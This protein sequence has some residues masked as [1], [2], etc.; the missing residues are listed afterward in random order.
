MFDYS[1]KSSN[2]QYYQQTGLYKKGAGNQYAQSSVNFTSQ[3]DTFEKSTKSDSKKG[4]SNGTKYVLGGLALAGLSAL[5]YFAT[6]GKVGKG[7]VKAAV[8]HV[9][10]T[11]AKSIDEAKKFAKD[12]LGVN[13]YDID[14][15]D[16]IN[17]LNEWLVGIHNKCKI[18][19]KYSYPKY[20]ANSD[21]E[22]GALACMYDGVLEVSHRDGYLMGINMSM[23][24][25][26]DKFLDFIFKDAKVIQRSTDGKYQIIDEVY[27]T[28][29]VR[30]FLNRVNKYNSKTT[31]FKE[32]LSIVTDLK[33]LEDAKIV[34]CKIKESNI[35]DFYCLNHELGHLR[36]QGSST[37]FNAMKK[38]AEFEELGE[39]PS[40]ITK[41]FINNKDIQYTAGQVS[42]YAKESPAEF[43]AETFAG[44]VSGKNFSDDVMALYR[45]YGGPSI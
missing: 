37:N 12:K 29:F 35:S 28:E 43:V 38:I 5:V 26:F 22:Q 27:D 18:L 32:K 33:R 1:I 16:V 20:I 39:T 42:E 40:K 14:D 13:Y 4:M 41:E 21:L 23:I 3:P 15:V 2:P 25:D 45:K 10:Y 24:K 7:S 34:N 8:E 36:H 31:T 6:K 9:D 17:C 30:N 44:L 19:D 11:P